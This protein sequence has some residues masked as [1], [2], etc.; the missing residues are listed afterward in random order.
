M[1]LDAA[2]NYTIDVLIEPRAG[3]P[4]ML[5]EGLKLHDGRARRRGTTA[6]QLERLAVAAAGHARSSPSNGK[7]KPSCTGRESVAATASA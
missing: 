7:Y 1:S 4:E 3:A 2:R 6:A 5:V